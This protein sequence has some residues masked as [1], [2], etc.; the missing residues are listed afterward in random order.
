[1]TSEH[2]RCIVIG[3]GNPDRGDDLAGRAVAQR[4]YG[5]VPDIV[6]VAESDGEATALIDCFDGVGSAYLVDACLSGVAAGTVRRFDVVDGPLP[7]HLF[8]V[9]THGFGLAQAI[10]LARALGQLPRRCV[11]YAIEG[12]SFEAGAPITP[13]VAGAVSDVAQRLRAEI[14]ALHPDEGLELCTKPR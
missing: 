8:G 11:V 2:A 13:S 3:V 4:L 10:E 6:T 1:M 7:Q 12:G 9:S 14:A 5:T